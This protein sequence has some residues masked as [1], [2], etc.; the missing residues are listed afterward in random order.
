MAQQERSG[1]S[2][3]RV[4]RNDAA[5]REANE[6]INDVAKSFD[7]DDEQVLPV[8][9]ECADASCSEIVQL[10]PAEYETVRREPTHFINAHGHS[11]NAGPWAQVIQ[12]SERYSVVE[13]VGQ[14]AEIVAELDPRTRAHDGRTEGAN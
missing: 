4:A 12:Q 7:L 1:L 14:A 10:T 13:K 5:F 3:E 6:N 2:A 11:R 9:C 8:I